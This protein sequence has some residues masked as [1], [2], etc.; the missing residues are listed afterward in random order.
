MNKI[1][2][3][4][5]GGLIVLF[6]LAILI[7]NLFGDTFSIFR[8]NWGLIWPFFIIIPGVFFWASWFSSKDR[9]EKW[10]LL[11][12]AGI[13]SFLGLTF[14]VNMFVS[15]YGDFG[16]IW[17]L[18]AFMYPG[19]VALAF[20]MAWFIQ[21]RKERGLMIVASILSVVSLVVLMISLTAYLSIG[22]F[23]VTKMW[24]LFI[25]CLGFVVLFSPIFKTAFKK[26][27]KYF[28]KTEAEWHEWGENFGRSFED[29]MEKKGKDFEK[30]MEDM[31][32]KIEK[33]VDEALGE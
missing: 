7:S 4:L 18:S 12:P 13:L 23:A 27:G 16:G 10:G 31:G 8:I 3:I 22:F 14:L 20:W 32:K 33:D 24:P 26:D 25:I 11:I 28:G 2:R 15:T 19:S 30:E 9:Q 29:K 6:G 21:G 1:F 17:I 5:F